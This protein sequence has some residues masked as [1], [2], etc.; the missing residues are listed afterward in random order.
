MI[1]DPATL[2]WRDAYKL[3]I[4][5][6]V[7]RPIAWLSTMNKE[8][9]ANV[10]PFSF[11]T[12]VA[13]KPTTIAFCPMRKADGTKKDTLVNIEATGE[14]VVNIV[15]ESL[16]AQMNVTSAEFPPEVNEFTEA[17]LTE[18][19]S[20]TVKP[21]R[22]GES[23]VSYE[24][25]LLQVIEIGEAEA[26]AGALVLGT[27][28]RIHVADELLEGGRI[29]PDVLQPVGR[30]AGPEYVRGTDRFTM[31]RPGRPNS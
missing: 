3:L 22:V 16:L 15:S 17:G 19:P 28:V 31:E 10:A 29:K 9:K 12:I 20:V 27:V 18:A 6:I 4:G 11:F 25:K 24:C 1:V 26:G 2:P 13:A 8:G 23:L 21:P 30:M 5:A 14:F 7:P